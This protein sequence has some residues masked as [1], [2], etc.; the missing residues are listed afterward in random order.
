[1]SL[2]FAFWRYFSNVVSRQKLGTLPTSSFSDAKLARCCY[3]SFLCISVR[4]LLFTQSH[5]YVCLKIIILTNKSKQTHLFNWRFTYSKFN[6]SWNDV[7][8]HWWWKEPRGSNLCSTHSRCKC[9]T[10]IMNFDYIRFD[11][12][13]RIS[14]VYLFT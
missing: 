5:K 10:V 13:A 12:L 1:M 6:M 4:I 11:Y 2:N 9:D 3:A 14:Y 8:L 7:W